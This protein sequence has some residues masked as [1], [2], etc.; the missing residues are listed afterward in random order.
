MLQPRDGCNIFKSQGA[1][2]VLLSNVAQKRVQMTMRLLNRCS[3]R[4][5]VLLVL[6]IL[7]SFEF[8]AG[9]L[10]TG[11]AQA[12]SAQKNPLEQARSAVESL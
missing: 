12:Q 3:F 9:A 8:S 6:S 4:S 7:V 11:S 1:R 5:A 10:L 2:N